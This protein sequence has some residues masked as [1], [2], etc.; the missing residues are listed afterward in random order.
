MHIGWNGGGHH[1]ALDA[2]REDAR[3]AA[4]DGFASFWLSQ[5]T[6]PDS[7]T[8]LAAIAFATYLQAAVPTIPVV[9]T[10][11]G[12]VLLW[13][14]LH[15]A[16][17]WWGTRL[18]DA[19]PVL[20][21]VRDDLPVGAEGRAPCAPIAVGCISRDDTSQPVLGQGAKRNQRAGGVADH[22]HARDTAVGRAVVSIR[23]EIPNRDATR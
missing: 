21:G 1:H 10:A 18:T 3:R 8:A 19:P 7:L 22:I 5:I 13:T 20:H 9:H 2:I 6:G 23:D 12:L 14:A 16:S 15:C 17:I 11:A 4:E